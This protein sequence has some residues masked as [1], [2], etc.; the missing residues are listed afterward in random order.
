MKNERLFSRIGAALTV[1]SLLIMV[2]LYAFSFSVK[3]NSSSDT[4]VLIYGTSSEETLPYT[5]LRNM[6]GSIGADYSIINEDY[7]D[8]DDDVVSDKE[9][10][11]PDEFSDYDAVV[12]IAVG[13]SAI[14]VM[15]DFSGNSLVKGFVLVNPIFDGNSDLTGLGDSFPIEPVAVFS[16]V[17]KASSVSELSDSE[18][19][20]ERLSG[21]DTVYGS[22]TG[23]SSV[24]AS[25]IQID[26][27]GN[28]F[29]YQSN[30]IFSEKS[31]SLM[32]SPIFQS[33]LANYLSAT[34][35]DSFVEFSQTRITGWYVWFVL[36]IFLFISG[37]CLVMAFIPVTGSRINTDDNNGSDKLAS[38]TCAIISILSVITVIVMSLI[39]SVKVFIGPFLL[40]LPAI[41]ILLYAI[42]RVRFYLKNYKLYHKRKYN[43]SIVVA[44]SGAIT[45]ALICVFA[46]LFGLF[47]FPMGSVNVLMALAVMFIDFISVFF[48]TRCDRLSREMGRGGCSY[49]GNKLMFV[50]TLVPGG[51]TMMYGLLFGMK[52]V[53]VAGL[54]GFIS[55]GLPFTAAYPIKKHTDSSVACAFVHAF[56]L[57][58]L[59]IYM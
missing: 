5:T 22:R 55:A 36:S 42:F 46:N 6:I 14:P 34:Y 48:L 20:Y 10:V 7:I 16:S 21:E 26:P 51:I 12:V 13:E 4:A 23:S 32:F 57:L 11:I 27:F 18:L 35:P 25:S 59:L 38:F 49:F 31:A 19:L 56:A 28:R 44:L 3:N 37:L 33:N 47:V 45:V 50:L 24:F 54:V 29:F 52:F 41:Y 8:S 17:D 1:I 2:F 43:T 39:S 15:K 53:I 9:N 58:L 40:F 30:G